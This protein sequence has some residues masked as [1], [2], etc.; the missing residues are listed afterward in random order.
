MNM[1]CQF[2]GTKSVA[3]HPSHE[4]FMHETETTVVNYFIAVKLCLTLKDRKMAQ[5]RPTHTHTQ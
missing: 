3:V 2:L 4:S 1:A 5:E